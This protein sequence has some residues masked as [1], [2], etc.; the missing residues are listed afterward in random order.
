MPQGRGFGALVLAAAT[1]T[2]CH[3][4]LKP[5]LRPTA[6]PPAARRHLVV[7]RFIAF[8]DSLTEGIAG[9][10][11]YPLK[12][13]EMLATSYTRDEPMVENAGRGGELASDA[14][15]RLA[16]VI[17]SA[18][19]DVV[20]L[21]EG[22]NDLNKDG[23][24]AHALAAVRTLILTAEDRGAHV[25]VATLPPERRGGSRAGTIDLLPA[26]DSGVA[27]LAE[28]LHVPLADVHDAMTLEM[29][30]PDGLHVLDAGNERIAQVFFD[31]ITRAF[32][33]VES[34]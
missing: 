16:A 15:P 8:G 29:I 14:V 26:F 30:A 33:I 18:H 22:V 28:E 32:A 25:I 23:D 27:K 34:R 2:G 24:V 7:R 9:A 11:A 1:A 10:V 4:G 6:P 31:A 12:L 5:V 3:S 13:G 20:M 17:D 19:P 21:M